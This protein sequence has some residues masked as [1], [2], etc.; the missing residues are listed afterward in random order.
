MCCGWL[1][2]GVAIGDGRVYHRASS[3]AQS[4]RSTK[5]RRGRSGSASCP[6]A[7]GADDHRR[8]DLLRRQDLPRRRRAPTSATRPSS[9]RWTP[10]PARPLA[11]L[12][13]P[14]A[15]RARRR[16]VAGDRRRV[17]PRRRRGLAGARLSTRPRAPLLLDGQRRPGLGRQ[18]PRGRQ[19]VGRLDRRGRGRHRHVQVAL[20]DGA[21]RHLGLRRREPGRALQRVAEDRK[22]VA[23]AGKTG[24]LYMLDRATGEP[25]YGIDE[26]PS[27]EPVQKT[28]A[29]Q[30]IPRNGEFIPHEFPTPQSDDRPHQEVA[31]ARAEE[32][33][34]RAA[35]RELDPP[36]RDRTLDGFM[37]GP[38]RRQ[39]AADRLQPE[40]EHVLH[41]LAV[42]TAGEIATPGSKWTEGKSTSAG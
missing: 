1:N 20:P 13:D 11:L 35:D 3:T 15:G 26:S 19:Q 23:Q 31:D 30:P 25:L 10:R 28:S 27:A 17:S 9:R 38:R 42:Q 32:P 12:H 7:G 18:R 16:V 21:P 41:L 24:W 40:D 29:T 39:L 36:G 37:P 2:R 22:G 14:G 33:Q 4:S 5:D 34:G 6:L 8:A